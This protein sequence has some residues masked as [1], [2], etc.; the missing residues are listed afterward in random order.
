MVWFDVVAV[1]LQVVG[2]FRCLYV[3]FGLAFLALLDC[4]LCSLPQFNSVDIVVSWC[5]CVSFCS[6][7]WLLL[8]FV[9]L[10]LFMVDLF[11]H[12][13]WGCLWFCLCL[14]VY[15]LLSYLCFWMRIL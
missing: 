14:G 6:M 4:C 2:L 3:G 11:V 13:V 1:S 5:E 8:W 12:C 15:V 9:L 10:I 7:I